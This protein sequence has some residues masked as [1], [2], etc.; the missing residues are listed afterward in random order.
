MGNADLA[1]I[2]AGRID[3]D[4]ESQTSA[5]RTCGMI[6][7]ILHG[8]LVLLGLIVCFVYIICVA[9]IVGTAAGSKK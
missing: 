4:G 8:V 9:A 1:A 6:A 2:R 5:G 3:P 7:T